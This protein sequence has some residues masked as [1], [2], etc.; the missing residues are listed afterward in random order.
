MNTKDR[1]SDIPEEE[2]ENE[3]TKFIDFL[4]VFKSL[5]SDTE[6]LMELESNSIKSILIEA[7]KLK[8]ISLDPIIEILNTELRKKQ[9]ARK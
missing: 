3:I 2:F 9:D 1:L 7:S 4:E 5:E 8:S 6:D